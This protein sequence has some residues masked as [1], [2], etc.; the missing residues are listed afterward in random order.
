[1]I[2]PGMPNSIIASGSL[3][4]FVSSVSGLGVGLTS[5]IQVSRPPYLTNGDH[6]IAI[7]E[8]STGSNPIIPPD[9][10]VTLYSTGTPG[11]FYI[12]RKIAANEPSLLFFQTMNP[13][14]GAHRGRVT[15]VA[16]RGNTFANALAVTSY[17]GASPV[18]PSISPTYDGT[19][20]AIFTRYATTVVPVPNAPPSGM[21]ER[22]AQIAGGGP[23]IFV[24]DKWPVPKGATGTRTVTFPSTGTGHAALVKL[25]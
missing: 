2:V 8:D 19:L 1:M 24:Y 9:G 5:F 16:Y 25:G 14:S 7:V 10:W 21:T 4:P 6:M 17:S 3:S 22:A 23:G 13:V 15:I 11:S 18:A 12:F 20:L